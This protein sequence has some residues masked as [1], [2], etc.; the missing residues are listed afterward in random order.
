MKTKNNNS[1]GGPDISAIIDGL[2]ESRSKSQPPQSNPLK[3]DPGEAEA[4]KS[5]YKG[6]LWEEFLECLNDPEDEATERTKLYLIDDDIVETLHQCDFGGK[7]NANV[8][9]CILRTFLVDNIERLRQVHRPR[10][11]SLLDKY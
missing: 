4:N 5:E 2:S 3:N 7:S 9:N 1:S 11:I 8:I 6:R 10:S